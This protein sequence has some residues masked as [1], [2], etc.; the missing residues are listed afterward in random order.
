[1]REKIF[2][3]CK[4]L[5]KIKLDVSSSSLAAEMWSKKRAGVIPNK[6]K[7]KY[8]VPPLSKSRVNKDN[9][10]FYKSLDNDHNYFK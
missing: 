4:A 7:T 8:Y 9:K 10:S 6:T 3:W 2:L 5:L 1:M